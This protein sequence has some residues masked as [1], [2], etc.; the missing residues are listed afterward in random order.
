MSAY[1]DGELGGAEQLALRSHIEA[2][3]GCRTEYEAILLTKRLVSNLRCREPREG[4][5][6]DILNRL[7]VCEAELSALG[8]WWQRFLSP[9]PNARRLAFLCSGMGV[10]LIA[11]AMIVPRIQP[12]TGSFAYVAK[13]ARVAEPRMPVEDLRFVHD[14]WMASRAPQFLEET[15]E[16]QPSYPGLRLS[17][18]SGQEAFPVLR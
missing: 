11:Y 17:P 9:P 14:P 8:A 15:R 2:C 5:E 18:A 13:P 4:L 3:E 10:A 12:D 7:S 16:V 6:S 1:I